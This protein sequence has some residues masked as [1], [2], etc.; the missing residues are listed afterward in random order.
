[1][2]CVICE[3]NEAVWAFVVNDIYRLLCQ[4]CLAVIPMKEK[5]GPGVNIIRV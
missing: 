2:I 4:D 3:K 5:W 1:M